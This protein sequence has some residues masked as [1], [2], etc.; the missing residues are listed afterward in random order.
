MAAVALTALLA[1]QSHM[2]ARADEPAELADRKVDFGRDVRPILAGHCFKCHGADKQESGLRLDRRDAALR[3]G[4][5]GERAIVPGD[6]GASFL[7]K[8]VADPEGDVVMPAEGR[9]LTDDEVATLRAW[10]D[11]GARFGA[12]ERETASGVVGEAPLKSDHWSLQTIRRPVVPST[13]IDAATT[14]GF[15]IESPIDSFIVR[16]LEEAALS[17]SP[18]A[19]RPTLIRRLYLDL[20][21]LAPSPDDVQRF[22]KDDR[23][24]AYERLVDRVLAS[25]RYGERWTQH[26]LDVVRFAQTNG[27]ETNVERPNAYRYRDWVIAALNRDKPYDRFVREQIAGDAVGE[28]AATGFLVAGPYDTVK[29]PDINLTL[30]QRQDELA[31]MIGTTGGALL[32]LTLGCAR[33]HNH[34]FDPITQRDFYALQAV[35]AGVQHGERPLATPIS[36]QTRQEVDALRQRVAAVKAQLEAFDP[37]LPRLR[38]AVNAKMNEERFAPITARFVRFTV[39]AT[40]LYEPCIDELEVFSTAIDGTSPENVALASRGVMATSS[41]DYQG[42]PIHQLPHINNGKYGNSQS[43]IS[44]ETGKGWVQIELPETAVIDRI[45]WGRDREEKYADRLATE[46]VIEVATEPDQWQVVADSNSR[47]PFGNADVGA[48]LYRLDGL[49]DDAL[50]RARAL[51]DEW[52]SL[53]A[54]LARLIQ[55]GAIV[56]AGTFVQPEATYRLY[57]GDPLQKREQVVPSAPEV[58]GGF[59]LPADAPEQQRRIALAEW[60]TSEKNPLTARVAVNRLWHYHFGRGIVATPSDFG[61]NGAQPTHPELLDWLASELIGSGWSLKRMHRLIVCS[62]TYRQA[63]AASAD[64]LARDA[65]NL[66]LWRFAP[67]RLEAEAIRDNILAASGAIDLAMYGPG[68]SAFAPNDN[69]VRVYQPKENWGPAEWR[70]MLYMQHIRMER[71]AVF[72]SF[73]C[74][75]AGQPAPRRS[76][77]TTPVQALDLLNSGFVVE[78]ADILAR[79]VNEEVGESVPDQI[80]AAF[81][82]T[83]GRAP[84]E[85]EADRA[86]ELV[87]KY[88]LAALCRAMFN[89]NEFLFVP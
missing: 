68:F 69:Y 58:L 24:D 15:S 53:D 13:S 50:P 5:L 72:G 43:W 16:R 12:G 3:G 4:E 63:G 85:V 55:P 84:D 83:L 22:V 2:A 88:G 79:R 11:A 44:N 74:P 28:D 81:L 78:Q 37:P 59:E 42:N 45:V 86:G 80:R 73:D 52:K 19:D 35:L 33:C 41:G 60:V 61:A 1:A 39:Q 38:P 17:P 47:V 6:S 7:I 77:S 49:S 31:D 70:R 51:I 65:D 25:P 87:Q 21:G 82:L 40:N 76:S 71:D 66:L 29:S 18:S 32:G 46:Y 89:A 14:A 34:K 67:R 10:I 56:Y 26:W 57:R 48:A 27:F 23:P 64:A 8:V 9:R 36:P 20:V 62:S 75:D 54:Q 30:M